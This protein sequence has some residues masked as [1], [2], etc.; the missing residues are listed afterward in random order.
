MR[1]RLVGVIVTLATLA[2]CGGGNDP[3][4]SL[5]AK[6]AQGR[7]SSQIFRLD[8]A[9]LA[10]SKTAGSE[11]TFQYKGEVILKPGTSGEERQTFDCTV[12]P[13]VGD[14]PPRVIRFQFNY[15]GSSSANG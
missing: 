6:E 2:S 15:L 1:A 4:A 8:E 10:A 5:C 3:M 11:G 14:A 13:A 12:A 7:M 9:K